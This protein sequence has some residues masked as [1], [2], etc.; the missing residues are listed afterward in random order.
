MRYSGSS[1]VNQPNTIANLS[2]AQILGPTNGQVL[3]YSSSTS[4]WENSAVSGG[5]LDSLT[6]VDTTPVSF[7]T[8]VPENSASAVSNAQKYLRF[9]EGSSQWRVSCS[10][11]TVF[12]GEYVFEIN[13]SLPSVTPN[14]LSGII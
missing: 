7:S 6:D 8:P 5:P 11:I 9:N 2:D 13:P 4:K 3:K 10:A 1:W 14:E 12:S